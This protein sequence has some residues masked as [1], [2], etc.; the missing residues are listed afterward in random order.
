[1]NSVKFQK[2]EKSLIIPN[3]GIEWNKMKSPKY[4]SGYDSGKHEVLL[5]FSSF[6]WK[7]SLFMASLDGN[8][9]RLTN[10]SKL[11]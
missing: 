1:M 2:D 8:I 3:N 11:K 7:N 4:M 10:E 6:V 9:Y 5:Y